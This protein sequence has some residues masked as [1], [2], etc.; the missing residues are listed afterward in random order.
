[1]SGND[2]FWNSAT[3]PS[4]P[5]QKYNDLVA[6]GWKIPAAA[7]FLLPPDVASNPCATAN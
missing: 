2:L 6:R 5:T 4:T 3:L 7:N 1:M